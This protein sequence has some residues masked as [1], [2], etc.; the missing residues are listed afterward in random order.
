MIRALEENQNARMAAF[1]SFLARKAVEPVSAAP[2]PIVIFTMPPAL[3]YVLGA[4]VLLD[5]VLIGLLLR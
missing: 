2:A 4:M 5:V 3:W 1:A